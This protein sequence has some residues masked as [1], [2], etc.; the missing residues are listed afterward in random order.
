MNYANRVRRFLLITTGTVS[1]ALCHIAQAQPD[2]VDL[3]RRDDMLMFPAGSPWDGNALDAEYKDAAVAPTAD[4]SSWLLYLPVTRSNEGHFQTLFRWNAAQNRFEDITANLLFDSSVAR[5]TYDVDFVDIDRDGDFDIVHSSPHG[6]FILVNDG[7]DQFSDETAA[8]L[9]HF[10]TIDCENVWDDTVAADVD[11]DG[12]ID[13]AFANRSFPLGDCP[14]DPDRHWGP[15]ALVYNDGTGHFPTVEYFGVPESNPV[16]DREGSSHGIEFADIDNDGRLD[17]IISHRANYISDVPETAVHLEYRLNTGDPNGDGRVDWAAPVTIDNSGYPINIE[18]FDFDNDGDLDIYQAMADTDQLVFNRLDSGSD[19]FPGSGTPAE[20]VIPEERT[21]Y[22]VAVGDLNNDGFFDIATPDADG[23]GTGRNTLMLNDAGTDVVLSNEALINDPS[24]YFRLSAAFGDFDGDDRLDMVWT[25]D[26]RKAS[27]GNPTVIRNVTTGAEDTTAPR[28]DTPALMLQGHGEAAAVF[29]VR[30]ADRVTDIDEIDAELDWTITGDLGTTH[31]VSTPVPLDWAA[32][33]TYQALLS[34]DDLTAGFQP[35]ETIESL[36]GTVT[37]RDGRNAAPGPNESTFTITPAQ[38]QALGTQLA[39]AG[40]A[41][42]GIA[43][44]EPTV[45]NPA[46]AQP[47]DGSGRM[48]IRLDITPL[49]LQPDADDFVVTIGGQPAP[50]I[51]GLR[52]ANEMWLVVDVPALVSTSELQ[53]SYRLCGIEVASS[54]QP[55]AVPFTSNPLDTDSVAV[56]DLSGS[57][58]DDRK[59]DSAKNAASLFIDTMRDNERI[60]VA[61]YRGYDGNLGNADVAFDIEPAGDGTNRAD[62]IGEVEAFS[63]SSSTPLGTGISEGLNELNSVP[64]A[65]RNDIRAL[66]LLSD[67]MENVPHFW[68]TPPGW[69]TPPSGLV[70]EP[71]AQ[72]FLAGGPGDD[73]I[74]HTISL[75]PDA[76]HDLMDEISAINTGGTSL[77]VDVQETPENLGSNIDLMELAGFESAHAQAGGVSLPNRLADG[78]EY[79]HATTTLQQRL[80]RIFHTIREKPVQ[81]DD[82]VAANLQRSRVDLLPFQVEPGLQFATVSLNWDASFDDPIQLIPPPGQAAGSIQQSATDSNVVFRI[83]EP[84]PGEWR[85][86]LPVQQAGTR[87]MLL[88]SGV[89]ADRGF[90]RV[91]SGDQPRYVGNEQ[92]RIQR[93]PAPGSSVP[94]ALMLVGDSPITGADVSG[95]I[96][97]PSHGEETIVLRDNGDAPDSVGGDG[98]YTGAFDST[99]MGGVFDAEVTANWTGSDGASRQRIYRTAVQLERRDSD[100]DGIDDVTEDR[101]G[102]DPQRPGDAGEDP[103][104]DG[105]VNWKEIDIGLDPFTGDNDDGG[106]DDGREICLGADPEFAGDDEGLLEDGD[107]DGLPEQWE[108]RFGLDPSDPADASGDPDGDGLTT[109]EEL[110]YCTDPLNPDTD[111]DHK[112]DGEEVAE[113]ADPTDPRNRVQALPEGQPTE[114]GGDPVQCPECTVGPIVYL[115]WILV[116][117]LFV[118]LL[119][120]LLRRR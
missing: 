17:M 70:H 19:P 92:I 93:R 43:I 98:V 26:S 67:G 105:L 85:A 88:I 7:S 82:A 75:G 61:W 86:A 24:P 25:A 37:A 99:E 104:G 83:A 111:G 1:L 95:V 62:A 60:G 52:V 39:G 50:V 11:A 46:P 34:C 22:D 12:D 78:Y 100:G 44:D 63:A 80:G 18:L 97:S 30:I 45:F 117:V 59:L 42:F 114:P 16:E 102:L 66:V 65:D 112:P 115:C 53:V 76:D 109:A 15:N 113:G 13:L 73:V 74:I 4:G 32:K 29:R 116:G 8:R 72:K 56:V 28:I 57:M 89:S 9:P 21:S 36:T 23:G 87:V 51:S 90:L 68:S 96:T 58:N 35:G 79:L 20:P 107:G 40:A 55:N 54:T 119:L 48:Q 33:L 38:G 27:D 14:P 5:D 120:V 110:R 103:D 49:N 118:L 84:V 94:L 2:P 101:Y 77:H 31:S 47:D 81:I 69:W 6:N 71:V 106:V 91:L 10:L 64:V 41:G 108:T 3:E